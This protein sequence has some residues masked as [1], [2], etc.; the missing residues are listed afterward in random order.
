[1]QKPVDELVKQAQAALDNNEP[2]AALRLCTEILNEDFNNVM[3]LHLTG[4]ALAR[5]G[6]YGLAC[7]LFRQVIKMAPSRAEAFNNMGMCYTEIWDLKNAEMCFMEA[8]RRDPKDWS[9]MHNMALLYLNRCDPHKALEWSDK[10]LK[11][12]PSNWNARETKAFAQLALGKWKE[13]WENFEV[14][15]GG[16]HRREWAYKEPPNREPRWDGTP[17]KTVVI[18]GEQGLGDEISFASIIPDAIRDCKK[19]I[20]DCDPRLEGLFKRSF[21]Q[22]DVYGTRQ[23]GKGVGWIANYDIDARCSGASLTRFYRNSDESFP[24]TPYLVADSERRIQWRALLDTFGPEPK[25]GIAWT[26]GL[27]DTGAKKR[28]IPVEQLAPVFANNAHFI[29]LQYKGD[30]PG[31]VGGKKLHNWNRATRTND[32]DDT[33]ALVAELDLVIAVNTSVVHLAGALGVPCWTLTPFK[34]RWF[35]GIKGKTLPWYKSVR[36]FRQSNDWKPVIQ[37]VADEL[38]ELCESS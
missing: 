2:D 12:E 30:V 8:L 35:Y 10:A 24:G 3:A 14:S 27:R 37:T 33:A 11:I 23:Q 18:Y 6:R 13:G 38:K 31:E 9:A 26:G 15:L 28:T 21:P 29:S 34:P 17:G 22:A 1:V 36:V 16:P 5:G 25:V 7:N 4:V 32:Y 20:I 19:V